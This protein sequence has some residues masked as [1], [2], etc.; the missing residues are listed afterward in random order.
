MCC[1]PWG[2]KELDM[3]EQLN[4]TEHTNMHI[5]SYV[6]IYKYIQIL[7]IG[8]Y[9][10]QYMCVSHSA[11]PA[12]HDP[13][14][15]SPPD[16]SCPWDSPAKNTEMGGH[17]LLQGIFPTQGTDSSLLH[18]RQILYHLSQQGSPT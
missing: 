12:L 11:M 4:C 8:M 7:R 9:Y 5:Y 3:T 13:R 6:Q 16:V 1:C 14:D 17:F 2:R 18:C 10:I 15:C